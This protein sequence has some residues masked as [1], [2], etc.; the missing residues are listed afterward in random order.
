MRSCKDITTVTGGPPPARRLAPCPAHPN[1]V[2]SDAR[3]GRHAVEP[4]RL[5]GDPDAVWQALA[6][7]LAHLPRTTVVANGTGYAH[8]EC[9][10]RVFGFVDD[11]E[12]ALRAGEG[13]IAVRSA[14]RSGY[15]DLGV[16]RRRVERIR[17][18]LRGRGVLQ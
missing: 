4:L 3:D 13:L 5:R 17:T 12:F 14:A 6:A 8:V 9:R 10:S 11:L 18:A 1:C 2:S 16:N 15:W 7:V